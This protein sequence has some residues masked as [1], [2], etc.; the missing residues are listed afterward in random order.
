MSLQLLA[1]SMS[2]VPVSS[3]IAV[4]FG[5][6]PGSALPPPPLWVVGH[7]TGLRHPN[8]PQTNLKAHH[9]CVLAS[10]A[11]HHQPKPFCFSLSMTGVLEALTP[12]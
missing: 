3:S 7:T 10:Q 9:L 12:S 6:S 4:L 11:V 8:L 2:L 5:R 1:T